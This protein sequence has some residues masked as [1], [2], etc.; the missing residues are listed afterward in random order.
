MINGDKIYLHTFNVYYRDGLDPFLDCVCRYLSG[1]EPIPV[2]EANAIHNLPKV[3]FTFTDLLLEQFFRDPSCLKKP[4]DVAMRYGLLGYSSGGRSGIFY[5]RKEYDNG[6]FRKVETALNSGTVQKQII[7]DLDIPKEGLDE[8][9]KVKIVWH[10]HHGK[11]VVGVYN[12]KNHHM[13]FLDFG[14]Y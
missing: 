12:T 2:S 14:H 13:I 10:N 9:R 5:L 8:L 1:R 3:T 4:Y 11:R 7:G 6:L